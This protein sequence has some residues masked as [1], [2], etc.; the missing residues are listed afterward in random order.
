MKQ[1][2]TF[3]AWDGSRVASQ[4]CLNRFAPHSSAG[5]RLDD[6]PLE[7]VRANDANDANRASCAKCANVFRGVQ[8]GV[9]HGLV[10]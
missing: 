7:L 2:Y 6:L 9:T 3:R 8:L 10:H 5:A 1:L 4:D